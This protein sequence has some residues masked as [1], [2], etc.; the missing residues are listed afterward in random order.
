MTP[1]P[2][3]PNTNNVF[4]LTTKVITDSRN[5][6]SDN[7]IKLTAAGY[8]TGNILE[9]ATSFMGQHGGLGSPLDRQ[10]ASG[11]LL[12]GAT[13]MWKYGKKDLGLA[14]ALTVNQVGY[15]FATKQGMADGQLGVTA[16]F[17]LNGAAMGFAWMTQPL[18]QKFG[19][20][21][22]Q[23][24]ASTQ[25]LRLKGGSTMQVA[26]QGFKEYGSTLVRKTLGH[27]HKM[28][29][30][31]LALS[32]V[33]WV[34]DAVMNK[35]WGWLGVVGCFVVGDSFSFLAKTEAEQH[36]KDQVPN[37]PKLAPTANQTPEKLDKV[38]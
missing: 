17:A 28:M 8:I 37:R 7:A 2:P 35:Q 13:L 30:T 38:A 16:G 9:G 29:A 33:P 4:H 12:T 14:A 25:K 26:L 24:K 34:V 19:T 36:S 32:N 31:N 11:I 27:P 3:P 18:E 15:Y 1:Q 20:F 21:G 10:I 22:Y 5:W 6:V 23:L